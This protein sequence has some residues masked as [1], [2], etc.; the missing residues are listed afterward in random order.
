MG[1]FLQII[2]VRWERSCA[3]LAGLRSAL[4][5]AHLGGSVP[6]WLGLGPCWRLVGRRSGDAVRRTTLQRLSCLGA[7]IRA[8]L[9]GPDMAGAPPPPAHG[10]SVG[11]FGR[12]KV[13]VGVGPKCGPKLGSTSGRCGVDV[14]PC[15]RRPLWDRRRPQDRGRPWDRRCLRRCRPRGRY[16]PDH[17]SADAH[18]IAEAHGAAAKG[19]IAAYGGASLQGIGAAHGIVADQGIAAAPTHGKHTAVGSPQPTGWSPPMGSWP[20]MGPR[21]DSTSTWGTLSTHESED[22]R[23][24]ATKRRCSRLWQEARSRH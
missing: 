17:G 2:L 13:W 18:A 1:S 19:I 16:R 6:C 23:R 15:D 21:A 3:L 12:T 8:A 4:V 20:P 10:R 11:R 7:S 22:L 5:V 24:R 14:R 9:D